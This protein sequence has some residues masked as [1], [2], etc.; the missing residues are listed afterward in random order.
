[1]S[2]WESYMGV[3]QR[4]NVSWNLVFLIYPI[5]G[6]IK[7]RARDLL[8]SYHKLIFIWSISENR[9]KFSGICLF[10]CLAG[11]ALLYFTLFYFC[12]VT[13]NL[14]LFFIYYTFIY[15]FCLCVSVHVFCVCHGLCVEV[16][17]PHLEVSSHH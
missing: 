7:D 11:F 9:C 4:R 14:N 5:L 2:E 17:G 10:V 15:L 6:C 1:M 13:G 8:S 3:I 12:L 16:R